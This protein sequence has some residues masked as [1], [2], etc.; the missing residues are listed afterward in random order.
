MKYFCLILAV[1]V[2]TLAPLLAAAQ[3]NDRDRGIDL[4]RQGK[5]LEALMILEGVVKQK[6]YASDAEALNYLGLAYATSD[7]TKKARKILEKAVKLQPQNSLYRSNLAYVYML[8]RQVDKSQQQAEK[9]LQIDP[10]NVSALYVMG[11][12]N[13]WEGKL[14]NASVAADKIIGID[15][16][17]TQAYVLKSEVYIARLGKNIA[18]GSTIKDQIDLLKQSADVLEEG[19]K[20]CQPSSACKELKEKLESAQVFH[21][22]YSKD[23]SVIPAVA[24]ASD[25]SVTPVKILRKPQASY[26]SNARSAGITGTVR[27]AIL[28]GADG[29][30]QHILKLRGL[31]YGLD[32]QALGAA[33]QIEFQ[34][35]MKDGKPV[36]TVVTVE[37][38]FSI[39]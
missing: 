15:P 3:Q 38:S 23:K 13:L 27:L 5:H 25:P 33:R 17:F 36:S 24:P 19:L 28:L 12:A 8:V 26:T 30:I 14:D 21:K 11:T 1:A 29:N 32:E 18:E 2:F 22:H 4:Y 20:R 7:D 37:Y 34:P 35:K 6:E 9:A 10:S 39:Y 16:A 31:G